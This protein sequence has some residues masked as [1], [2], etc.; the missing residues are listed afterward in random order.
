MNGE[1]VLEVSV[2]EFSRRFAGMVARHK[3]LQRVA[4]VGEITD[5]KRWS[6]GN[7]NMT[8]K[9]GEAILG[10]FSFASEARRFPIL[11]EGLMVRAEGSIEIRPNRSLYQLR[12]LA[13]SLVG[14]GKLAAEIEELRMRL[15]AEGAFDASRKRGIPAFP[16]RIA[17]ITSD[18]D[19]R[20]DFEG[21]LRADAPHVQVE[22][23]RTR[24]QGKGAEIDVA[25]A[26]D[27]AS[28]VKADVV[29]ITRGGGSSEDR[30]TF[31]LEA[32]VRA[33]LRSPHPVI[34]ALGHLKNRHLADEVADLALPTPTAAAVHLGKEWSRAFELLERLHA[35]LRRGYRSVLAG[36]TQSVRFAD[37]ALERSAE[38]LLNRRLEQM[39]GFERLLDQRSP[40]AR[41][42]AWRL[43]LVRSA[44]ALARSSERLQ[45]QWLRRLER[46]QASLDGEDPTRPLAR[47]YAIVTK[48][49][50]AVHDV[51]VLAYG[52]VVTARVAHGTFD[53]RVESV[54]AE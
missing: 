14:E 52:D 24:V 38:G 8:L 12:A 44:A 15:R 5:L 49:G 7:L 11:R 30:L 13:V 16:R 22:F 32:V 33:I 41:V 18:D 26:L 37:V 3:T 31:N 20:A 6:D 4:I 40:A 9:E 51:A 39:R 23:F 48:A 1:P 54:H 28:R 50:V 2:G 25:E 53:A 17:L 46:A 10:C 45:Q 27:R 34:T 47:G 35:A 19:A 42:G 43:G 21:R 29:V 36:K